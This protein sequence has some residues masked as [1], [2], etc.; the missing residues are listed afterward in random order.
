MRSL[1]SAAT[2]RLA[3]AAAGFLLVVPGCT[4]P[5]PKP[6]PQACAP[7]TRCL[8]VD[9]DG[10]PNPDG[11]SLAQCSGTFPDYIVPATLFPTTYSGPWFF[12]AA[13]YPKQPPPPEDLPWKKLDFRAGKKQA[14]AYL[15]ALRDYSFEG[16]VEAD[17]RPEKN[18]RRRWYH[19]PLMNYYHER[20]L[21]HGVT[22]ERPL[23]G[24]ELGIKRGVTV[25]NFAVGFYNDIGAYS[26]G[27]VFASP[28][29]PDASKAQF[30]EGAMV[31][32]ILF[33]A[34]TPDNFDD[35]PGDI[36]EGAPSWQIATQ[37]KP[38]TE[39]VLTTVRLLQ[40]DV[41]VRDDRAQPSGW[42]FGTFAF[43]RTATDEPAWKRLRPVGLMW[44]NDPG[45]TPDNVKRHPLKESV[46]S[47]E[48][49]AYAK[50][51]L[52][53]AGRVNGPV[54]NPESACMSCHQ[55]AQVPASAGMVPDKGCTT[56]QKLY[57]FRNIASREAFGAT[58]EKNK[59]EPA[60]DP[61]PATLDFSLQL[62]AAVQSLETYGNVNPCTPPSVLRAPPPGPI[63]EP[64]IER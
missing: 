52:G 12:L 47:D 11:T 31:F 13:D 58:D 51:H 50:G 4:K 9:A 17:F 63:A 40:M 3:L 21:V 1:V 48:I 33:S 38:T 54:D 45:I 25:R 55:T 29:R 15:Y 37:E 2:K 53:W 10:R 36:L 26:F 41:A 46:V 44:G 27:Q 34:A 22:E 19:A 28:N 16:M 6:R 42:V 23:E 49:P 61:K 18:A 24:P 64:R 35:P 60:P 8:A 56:D 57:W 43:D 30:E 32:K 20:E 39:G 7:G 5:Q 59:C 14:D 62:A